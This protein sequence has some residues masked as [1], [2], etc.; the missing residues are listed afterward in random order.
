MKTGRRFC[1]RWAPAGGKQFFRTRFLLSVAKAAL[2]TDG[3][4]RE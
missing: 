2:I 3:V 4:R 1:G